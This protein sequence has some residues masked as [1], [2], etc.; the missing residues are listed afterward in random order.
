MPAEGIGLC[1]SGG[2]FRATLFH[3]GAVL[4]L[5]ELGILE[6]VRTICSVSG[7]SITNGHLAATHP[8]PSPG[9]EW[10]ARI[11][12]PLRQF[13]RKDIRTW[14]FFKSFLPGVTTLDGLI[15][16]YDRLLRF[17]KLAAIP[18]RPVFV[19]CATDLAFGAN[20]EFSKATMGDWQL[21]YTPT[22]ADWPLA[23]AVAASACFPPLFNPM[24]MR[25]VGPFTGGAAEENDHEAWLVA[26]SDLRLTD[27]GNYDNMGLEPVW[28]DH[29]YVLVS[30]AGGLFE[31]EPDENLAQRIQRYVAI[32]EAQT[33]Y[34]R[35]RWLF[36]KSDR[37]ELKAAY[38][39]VSSAR[40]RYVADN[41][42]GY[43]KTLAKKV[44]AAIRT[45]LDAF[46]DAEAEVLQNHGYLLADVAVTV[47]ARGLLPATPP[48]P[49]P[50]FPAWLPQNGNDD[51]VRAALSDS[52]KRKTLGRGWM[53]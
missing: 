11:A 24:R 1:L 53:W 29:E 10:G 43:S 16:H 39:A 40:A 44:I 2:G 8:W 37:G 49:S 27:G 7:G 23:K 17:T 14:P 46:S 47:H 42:L 34:L 41:A 3:L 51:H 52:D 38:W 26:K 6:R 36:D 45:D 31:F 4:R 30:D 35:K 33:R 15:P 22:P 21:G 18:A 9:P 20:F 12:G 32:Q 19:F 13:T 5:H 28:K 25:G 48:P 50:P